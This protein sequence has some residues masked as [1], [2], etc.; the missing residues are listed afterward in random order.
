MAND[1]KKVEMKLEETLKVQLIEMIKRKYSKEQINVILQKVGCKTLES[2][3][4]FD[5]LKSLYAYKSNVL[6]NAMLKDV[7]QNYPDKMP[8][9]KKALSSK[10]KVYAMEYTDLLS[11]A[12]YGKSFLERV[13]EELINSLIK[14]DA[15][16]QEADK[17]I[18]YVKG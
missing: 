16:L 15:V 10:D 7:Q 17:L 2:E 9:I 12:M 18:N 11:A 5:F 13:I 1:K 6:F 3:C 8:A 4:F 14:I